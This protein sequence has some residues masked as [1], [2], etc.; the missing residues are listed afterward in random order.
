MPC[1]GTGE[2]TG[3]APSARDGYRMGAQSLV[4]GIYAAHLSSKSM[5][6]LKRGP[7]VPKSS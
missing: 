4:R 1:T 7:T 5:T 3:T 6:A 2:G